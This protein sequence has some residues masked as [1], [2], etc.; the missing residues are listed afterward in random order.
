MYRI[1]SFFHNWYHVSCGEHA[2]VIVLSL[3]FTF[4][5]LL[6]GQGIL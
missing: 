2:V 6:I 3:A 5:S 1:T 4:V